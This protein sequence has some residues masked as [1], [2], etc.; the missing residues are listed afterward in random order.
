MR[1][2]KEGTKD[3][4][5]ESKCLEQL[6]HTTGAPHQLSKSQI[7]LDIHIC[8]ALSSQKLLRASITLL[9]SHGRKQSSEKLSNLQKLHS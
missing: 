2:V 5:G 1:E 8:Y 6:T 7:L 9:F 3:T 4:S